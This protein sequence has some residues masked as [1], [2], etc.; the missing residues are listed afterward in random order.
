[1]VL[2]RYL[3]C[4]SRPRLLTNGIIKRKLLS[5]QQSYDASTPFLSFIKRWNEKNLQAVEMETVN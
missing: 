5:K 1:M 4:Q 3:A 2:L